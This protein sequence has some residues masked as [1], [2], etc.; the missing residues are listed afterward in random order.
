MMQAQEG[1]EDGTSKLQFA[2]TPSRLP[3]APVYYHNT[4]YLQWEMGKIELNSIK[5]CIK[6]WNYVEHRRTN[7]PSGV[8]TRHGTI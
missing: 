3:L 2:E 5:S 4:D 7:T 1:W 8:G 6:P